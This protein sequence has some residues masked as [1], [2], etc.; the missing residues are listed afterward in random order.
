MRIRWRGFE[1]PTSVVHEAETLT[2]SYGKFIAE[3]F[4]RGYGHTIGNS[5]RRVLISSLEGTAVT[6]VRIHGI[7]HEFTAIKGVVEDVTQIVLNFK[8]L[9]IKLHTDVPLTLTVEKSGKG[10]VTAADVQETDQCEVVNKDLVL[11]TLADDVDFSAEFTVAK[12]RGYVTAEENATKDDAIGV[13]PIDSIFSPVRRISYSTQNTRVGQMTNYDRLIIEIWTDGTM[14]PEMALVEAATILRKH[15]NAFVNYAELGEELVHGK[16]IAGELEMPEEPAEDHEMKEKLAM[17]VSV[18]DPSVRAENCLDN[19]GI[20]T[21]GDL[22]GHSEPEMLRIQNF[23]R[24]S[25]REIKR[26]LQDMGLGF[27]EAEAAAEEES[28]G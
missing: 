16:K 25:L 27:A 2:S 21:I 4:E 19:A 23:G 14:A 20:K 12:G 5:L 15:F 17:P 24:T 1:L 10:P 13:I 26:K 11:C 28:E 3:P 9:L 8:E 18:L 22:I 6:S 7:D